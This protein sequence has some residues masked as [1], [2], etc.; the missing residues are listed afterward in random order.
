MDELLDEVKAMLAA[1][2]SLS[3]VT[4]DVD[5]ALAV[6]VVRVVTGRVA[7]IDVRHGRV[8]VHAPADT[9]APVQRAFAPTRSAPNGIAFD[10]GRHPDALAAI[11]RRVQVQRLTWQLRTA[12]P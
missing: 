5:D 11:R 8:L 4:I 1:I 2:A 6:A 7:R 10:P 9:I 12:S 3:A